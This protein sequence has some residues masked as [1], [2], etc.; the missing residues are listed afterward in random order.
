VVHRLEALAEEGIGASAAKG[1][2]KV[3][4]WPILCGGGGDPFLRVVLCLCGNLHLSFLTFQSAPE[5][6]VPLQDAV[7]RLK[8]HP[9][10][11]SFSGVTKARI[12]AVLAT[13]DRESDDMVDTVF[14]LLDDV[15]PSF[16]P[17]ARPGTRFC[18]GAST[19]HIAWHI[20][21]L[22]R[23]STRLDREGR[24]YWI[25]P[26]RAIG[27]VEPVYL[28]PD[29]G[30]FI[31]GHPVPKSPNSAYRLT[32]EFRQILLSPEDRWRSRLTEW[33]REDNIRLRLELQAKLAKVARSAVD[34]KHEDLIDACKEYYAPQF[35]QGFRV[36]YVD[37]GDGDRITDAQRAELANAGVTISLGDSMPDI[38][39][40]NPTTEAL[41]VVEAVTS[42]GE[43]DLHKVQQLKALADRSKKPS[44]G[45]TTAY[46]TWKAA[47]ARQSRYKNLA[48]GTH[49]WIMEDPAK[50]FSVTA[51]TQG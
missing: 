51:A 15:T 36:I 8:D 38:L 17:R 49:L 9:L 25:K 4:S 18:D 1:V 3:K 22:Q 13:I 45:F 33:I 30:A 50:Q 11:S 2:N 37:D 41:W 48:V 27:A 10:P 20:G 24:D 29:T 7:R 46:Q 43:V 5:T 19:Q 28:Q 40:W 6:L 34:T 42:D 32:E 16:Y 35:L 44:I 26:L 47:A 14:A 12:R 31:L 39:L 21:S 23:D